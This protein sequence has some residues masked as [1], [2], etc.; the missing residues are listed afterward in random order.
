MP[1]VTIEGPSLP[2]DNKRQLVLSIT[3]MISRSYKW[4]AERIIVIVHEN[5]DENV[6]RGGILI[7]DKKRPQE[8]TDSKS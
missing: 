3:D 8:R 6:A 5:P 1:T 7:A 4:P 2:L